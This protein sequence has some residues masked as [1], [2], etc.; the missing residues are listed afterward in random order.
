M[1]CQV[2]HLQNMK[3]TVYERSNLSNQQHAYDS[4]NS[5]LYECSRMS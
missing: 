3:M 5:G 4:Q 2:Q 1:F